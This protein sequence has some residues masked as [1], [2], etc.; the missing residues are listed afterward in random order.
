MMNQILVL[1]RSSSVDY[2]LCLF[3]QA[4][5]AGLPVSEAS[6]H[7]LST[8]W[9][10]AYRRMKLRDLIN[11]DFSHRVENVLDS[12]P[13]ATIVWHFTDISKIEC[14]QKTKSEHCKEKASCSSSGVSGSD[15]RSLRKGVQ[16]VN[17]NLCIF[18]QTTDVKARLSDKISQAS[19]L[20]YKV[21]IHLAV[22]I[23]SIAAEAKY[24]LT[25]LSA[26]T[27]YTSKTKEESTSTNLAMIW[28]CKE[29]H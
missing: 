1:K 27:R 26:F 9:T 7:G 11:I 23:D 12:T 29:L 20:D 22:V 5:Q 24:H 4:R 21:G 3:C 8:L 18:C 19:D 25:C 15:R 14:L 28:L 6:D 13:T 2:S 17:W 16:P 10:D